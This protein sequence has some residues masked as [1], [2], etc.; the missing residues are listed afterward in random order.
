[1]L[2][3]S[4]NLPLLGL[5]AAV[6]SLPAAVKAA[7]APYDLPRFQP[8]LDASKLQAPKSSPA[9]VEHGEFAGK[10]NEFF[11]LDESGQRIVFTATGDSRRSELRQMTGDWDTST[12][13]ERALIARVKVLVPETPELG[14]FTFLQVHDKEEDGEGL[15]KP[16]IR[17]TWR[18]SRSG[19]RDHLWA[20][21]RVPADAS[22][23]I[24]LENLGSEWVD[25]GPRPDGSFDASIRVRDNRLR[26][27]IDGEKK[28]DK[29]VSYWAGLSNYFKAGV[30]NQDPGTS[31]AIF[32]ALRYVS[33]DEEASATSSGAAAGAPPAEPS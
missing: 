21:L 1:M 23:P 13:E 10:S 9:M 29:D 31:V 17:V 19:V 7:E 24:S 3:C 16:L 33:G 18:R 2:R 4:S 32:E 27:T 11:H 8:V 28:I 30:Y 12:P 20:G 25:L 15:N 26:V 5:T 22:R 6:L 14:Q